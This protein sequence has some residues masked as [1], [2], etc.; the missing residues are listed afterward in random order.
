MAETPKYERQNTIQP[1][2][3][4]T[5]FAQAGHAL[6]SASDIIGKL[7][8]DFAQRASQQQATL[9]GIEAAKQGK[10]PLPFA[11]T[12]ADRSFE[13]AYNKE[14]A[15]NIN[16]EG[17]KLINQ[18]SQ[19]ASKLPTANSLN[20]FEQ[21]A[22]Q[23][24]EKLVS[25]AP[26]SLQ[27][28]LKRS[29]ES[30]YQSSFY[31]LAN[32]VEASNRQY[33]ESQRALQDNQQNEKI[34]NTALSDQGVGS[35]Q[36]LEDRLDTIDSREALYKETGGADGYR[37]DE[38]EAQRKA[39]V[40]RFQMGT[41]QREYVEAQK[42]KKG[43]DY[44]AN[45]RESKPEG[46]SPSEHDALVKGV[47]SY[48]NEYQAALSQQQFI[49]FIKYDGMIDTGKMTES[50]MIQ[51]K[52]ETSEVEY[53]KL[54]HKLAV[55][56][57]KVDKQTALFNEAAGNLEDA[58][59]MSRYSGS[60]VDSI[61]GKA[62]QL[63]EGSMSQQGQ[64]HVATLAEK[65]LLAQRINA[66][67]PALAKELSRVA[68]Y[69]GVQQATE[70]ARAVEFLKQSHDGVTISDLSKEDEVMFDT[71]A[72][73]QANTE[74]DPNE[75]L[76]LARQSYN[77]DDNTRVSRLERL[78]GYLQDSK[79]KVG[80]PTLQ[81]KIVSGLGGQ[82][83]FGRNSVV[84]TGLDVAFLSAVTA[85]A[86]ICETPKQAE[87]L[88]FEQMK[89]VY[90]EVDINDRPEMMKLGPP[91]EMYNDR[92]RAL[93]EIIASNQEQ[94]SSGGF[95]LNELSGA[96]KLPDDKDLYT[97]A[98]I[99]SKL[100]IMV[101]GQE[102]QVIIQP[103]QSTKMPNDGRISYAFAYLDENKAPVPL[104][105]FKTGQ[106]ARWYLDYGARQKW[107]EDR[108]GR[109]IE[110]AKEKREYTKNLDRLIGEEFAHD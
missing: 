106:T 21:H 36:A 59:F 83:L 1:G 40:Q 7:G 11:V 8:G 42:D 104:I 16:Y 79:L 109:L 43:A 97:R 96:D 46:M 23:S 101:D 82:R 2:S 15:N 57:A 88:A 61:F 29:L 76:K 39:A 20:D 64:P 74:N 33:L 32:R 108:K 63:Y 27:P 102:R 35:R 77:V 87:K 99:T 66:P 25:Q 58:G 48:A 89:G 93:K 50:S 91:K 98:P 18:L 55:H 78:R 67:V 103:D 80:T 71:F 73:L 49:N 30:S 54:E 70:A 19:T 4:T 52:N 105:D 94:V 69:G 9:Q 45:L 81:S 65:A 24:I 3:A 107:F 95:V 110:E 44:I 17:N 34:S 37:P 28:D 12:Q 53:A 60:E 84:P 41:H 90:K 86:P 100:K 68:N 92:V 13:E 75:N 47:L 14:R 56:S 31:Q 26:K 6:G 10:K 22:T 38:A 51:A 72:N 62:V 5:G 85:Y